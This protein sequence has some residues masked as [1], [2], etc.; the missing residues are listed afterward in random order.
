MKQF[1]VTSLENGMTLEKY[2]R[3]LLKEAPLSFIYKAFRKKD[4]RVNG[5][6][7]KE[8]FVVKT[9]DVV[10]VYISDSQLEEFKKKLDIT[11]MDEISSWIIYED[12]NIILI[13]KPRG[14]LVQKDAGSR[15]KALDQMVVEYL[16]FKGEYDPRRNSSFKPGPAH[17][18]DRNTSGIVIFGK[19]HDTLVYLFELLKE[20]ERIHKKYISLVC[21]E[22]LEDGEVDAP[23][24][25]NYPS[26]KVVICPTKD[27]GKEALTKYHVLENLKDFT[28]LELSLITGRTHQI[29]VHMSYIRHHVVGDGKY[30][31]FK[32]NNLLKK[33]YGFENQ[34]LHAYK[35]SFDTLKKPLAYLSN[36]TFTAPLN[37][38]YI[39]LLEK[40]KNEQSLE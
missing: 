8:K 1:V 22:I 31:D 2:V 11:P 23:M 35:L 37:E 15:D 20:H 4:I 6:W 24:R 3:K 16:M 14:I 21:G 30:G 25:K 12:K 9:D 7:E 29:R 19:N 5:H 34:F 38:E 33:K 13:N 40:I 10:S 27:G 28:L 18:I 26:T 17:R 36:K 32:V 39:T